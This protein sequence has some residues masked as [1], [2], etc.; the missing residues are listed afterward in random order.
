MDEDLRLSFAYRSPD[1]YASLS[2]SDQATRAVI[3]TDECV[4]D[5]DQFFV[6]GCLLVPV[7]GSDEEAILGIWARLTKQNFEEIRQ[8]RNV[9]GCQHESPF[10]AR[11]ANELPLSLWPSTLS[12]KCRLHLG[13]PGLRPALGVD[14]LEHPLGREQ[15]DGIN[16]ERAKALS[17]AMESSADGEN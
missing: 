6:R 4:I 5:D 9:P 16:L 15:R 12:V 2:E 13:P 3:N 10:A 14:P 7:H 17:I 1:P 11:L 8:L